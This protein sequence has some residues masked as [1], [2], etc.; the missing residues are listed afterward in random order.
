MEFRKPVERNARIEVMLDVI[1]HVLRR[2]KDVL[3]QGSARG[4]GMRVRVAPALDRGMLGDT[5]DTKNQDEPGE[6]RN[7]PVHQEQMQRAEP[8]KGQHHR[9][10]KSI[11]G[12]KKSAADAAVS[13]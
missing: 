5:A 4:S 11:P 3:E 10:V 6:E 12:E 2:H 13:R 7:K 8:R 9:H 1:I